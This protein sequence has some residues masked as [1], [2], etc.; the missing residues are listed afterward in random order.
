MGNCTFYLPAELSPSRRRILLTA[1]SRE[2]IRSQRF[3]AGSWLDTPKR[4]TWTHTFQIISNMYYTLMVDGDNS[5][6]F[7]TYLSDT[8]GHDSIGTP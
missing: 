7:L 1:F 5:Q 4:Q 6:R 8:Q 3:L 2:V